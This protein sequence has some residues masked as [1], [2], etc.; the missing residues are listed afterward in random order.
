MNVP[1]RNC[2]IKL[3]VDNANPPPFNM[4]CLDSKDVFQT[5]R[6]NAAKYKE[7]S[8]LKYGK[9]KEEVEAEV[10]ARRAFGAEDKPDEEGELTLE[11]LFK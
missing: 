9:T 4:V 7:M 5:N 11:E 6:E 2:L 8:K 1:S 3:M 10:A